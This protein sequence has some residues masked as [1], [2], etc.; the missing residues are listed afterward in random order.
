[1]GEASMRKWKR[2][3]LRA[4]ADEDLSPRAGLSRED[5]ELWAQARENVIRARALHMRLRER[6][7]RAFERFIVYALRRG[8][9]VFGPGVAEVCHG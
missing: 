6:R 1:M 2:W 9:T 8:F 7:R 4:H 5:L 3:V